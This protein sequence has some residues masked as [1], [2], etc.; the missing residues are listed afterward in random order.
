MIT[1]FGSHD[2]RGRELQEWLLLLLRYA[3]TREPSDLSAALVMA[4]ELDSL[5]A[6]WR[7]GAP[8]FFLRTSDEVCAAIISGENEYNNAI[9][10]RHAARIEDVRM[11][12]A[13][14]A[15]IGHRSTTEPQPSDA[16]NKRRTDQGLWRGLR[17]K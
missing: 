15:A 5:G 14:E 6:R 12:R 1:D 13:F 16:R 9:L 17:T 8:R 3:I 10:R 11:R 7:P 2:W 4:D